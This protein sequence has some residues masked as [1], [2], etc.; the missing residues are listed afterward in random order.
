MNFSSIYKSW[1]K[2]EVPTVRDSEP[3]SSAL[4]YVRK[5]RLHREKDFKRSRLRAGDARR[6]DSSVR[7]FSISAVFIPGTN[8]RIPQRFRELSPHL[9]EWS[10]NAESS[11]RSPEASQ[12]TLEP[13]YITP[14][15]VTYVRGVAPRAR[16]PITELYFNNILED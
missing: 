14:G 8:V 5:I 3:A 2:V 4:A 1:E 15:S 7:R 16:E 11:P 12:R 9:S 6:S 10:A 13:C